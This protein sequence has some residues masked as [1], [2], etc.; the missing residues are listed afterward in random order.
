MTPSTTDRRASYEP[1]PARVERFGRHVA[2]FV[3]RYLNGWKP[4]RAHWN[5]EDGC[6]FKGC[7]DLAA[8]TGERSFF[9]FVY[10]EVSMRVAPDGRISGFDP[11]EFNIDNINAGK[12]LFAL[13]AR[14]GE[15]RFLHAIEAQQEQLFRHPRTQSGNF[16]HKKIYPNQ[17]WLDGL[18]MAQPF[19]C[20]YARLKDRQDICEDVLRQFAHVRS[21]MRDAVSGLYYH[22]W[23]ESR[24]ERWSDPRTGLSQCFWGRAMGWFV[25]ALVDCIDVL[26]SAHAEGRA[27][28]TEMLND[29][30]NALMRVRSPQ[31]LWF[32]VLDQ[33]GRQGNYE[34][35]SASLMIAYALMKGARLG[36]LPEELGTAGLHSFHACVTR[37]LTEHELAGICGVAG[38]G[39]VPYRD[40]SF[41]YYISEPVVANDPKGAGA[42]LMAL[43]EA[44]LR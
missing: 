33:G 20:A 3:A 4:F 41:E 40:G 14:S 34:E 18:Y 43:S 39:N 42:F 17:V 2:P 38:L 1:F 22:G 12:A 26:G 24:A 32:Q 29:A 44:C 13:Y 35:A 31:G 9:D 10:T 23:D 37:F 11:D 30:A 25:M 8:A 16:W 36:A 5:Y 27:M 6:V 7:L 15:A 19:Q 21:V 28:L